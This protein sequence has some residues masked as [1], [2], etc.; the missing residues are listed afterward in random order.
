[1]MLAK[2]RHGR[3]YLLS[4]PTVELMTTD[5][6][7]PS[8]K[9]V[10]NCSSVIPRAGARPCCHGAPHRSLETPRPFRLGWRSRDVGL[11]RSA[12]RADRHLLTQR[13]MDSPQ[14]PRASTPTSGAVRT[15]QSTTRPKEEAMTI[16]PYLFFNGRCEEA[17]D[18]YKKTLGAN[19]DMVMRFREN[20]D[21]RGSQRCRRIPTRSCTPPSPSAMPW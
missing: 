15:R 17:L 4:R 7:L 21:P 10:P 9:E 1:M 19:V 8:Q 11:H 12:G 6:L 20:P 18:F 13:M 2:G 14:P 3:K 5:Q 16:Q